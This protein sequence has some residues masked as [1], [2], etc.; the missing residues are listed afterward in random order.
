[1]IGSLVK[2]KR[3]TGLKLTSHAVQINH[4]N[5][6][7][8]KL[9]FLGSKLRQSLPWQHCPGRTSRGKDGCQDSCQK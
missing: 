6:E 7:E 3:G 9:I 8:T 4:L 5:V 1:M 2:I